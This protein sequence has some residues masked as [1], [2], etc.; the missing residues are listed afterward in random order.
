LITRLDF[1]LSDEVSRQVS[2]V[3]NVFGDEAHS[4]NKVVECRMPGFQVIDKGLDMLIEL[5]QLC[6][7]LPN[8]DTVNIYQFRFPLCLLLQH[9]LYIRKTSQDDTIESLLEF[10]ERR[11]KLLNLW[12]LPHHP[13]RSPEYITLAC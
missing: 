1:L 5:S 9:D 6:R 11:V 3:P 12:F 10:L 2:I 13:N 8:N 7:V 4:L